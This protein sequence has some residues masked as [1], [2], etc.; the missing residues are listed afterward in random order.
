MTTSFPEHKP[1]LQFHP[2]TKAAPMASIAQTT[3]PLT[4]KQF[5]YHIPPAINKNPNLLP[6]EPSWIA[7]ISRITK[8]P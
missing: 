4:I 8:P 7:Q 3:S 2:S 6:S 1:I 5:Q